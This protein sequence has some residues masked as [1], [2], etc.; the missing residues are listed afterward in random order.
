M[1]VCLFSHVGFLGP[2]LV[3]SVRPS[4]SVLSG[5]YSVSRIKMESAVHKISTL[6][7]VVSLKSLKGC[8]KV[9]AKAQDM[10]VGVPKIE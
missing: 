6:I 10:D 4:G 5:L 3:C 8:I 9:K 1:F 7:P 2:H